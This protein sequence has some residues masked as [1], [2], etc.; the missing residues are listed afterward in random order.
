MITGGA[1][2][3]SNFSD[4]TQRYDTTRP[5]LGNRGGTG[6]TGMDIYTD[7]E[8]FSHKAG[9]VFDSFNAANPKRPKFASECCSCSSSRTAQLGDM[10]LGTDSGKP[11]GL[12]CTA[13]QS[14]ASNSRPFMS[15]TMVWTLFDYNG[16]SHGWPRV[17]SAYGQFDIAGFMKN[18]AHWYR[19]WWLSAVPPTDASRPVGFGAAHSCHAYMEGGVKV[20][21][22]AA[23]VDLYE[24]G[25]KTST[26]Q[27]SPLITAGLAVTNSAA[28]NFTA[29]CIGADGTPTASG[30]ILQPGSASTI[31]LSLDVPSVATGTGTTLFLDGH[32]AAMLRAEIV[33]SAGTVVGNS[34]ANVS[35]AVTAGPGRVIATH[36]GDNACHEPNHGSW[37]SAYAGLVRGIVQVTEH[38]AGSLRQRAL[39]AAISMDLAHTAVPLDDTVAPSS[40]TVVA[41]SPGLTSATVQIP[42]S[43]LPEHSVLATATS[44]L[45]TEQVWV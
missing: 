3:A 28:R 10:G 23:S 43:A 13:E 24:D 17:S 8:G 31:R 5:T 35:F 14:N 30:T 12:S 37:H 29:V 44:S 1:D 19:T 26:A 39:L 6:S 9:E 18:T 20:E 4:I 22:E 25:V 34:S 16:E 7:V 2:G 40:I 15:G 36:N 41:S 42:V 33:D 27:V 38:R 32:D 11:G 45:E 21:T